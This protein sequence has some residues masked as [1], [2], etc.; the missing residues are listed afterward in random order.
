MSFK[1]RQAWLVAPGRFEI[2]EAEINPGWEDVVVKV[3]AC[4]LCN[5][6]QNHWKGKLGTCPQT[7]GHEVA[8]TIVAIG[9]GIPKGQF[10]EGQPVT[11]FV[12]PM[13][14]FADY[15]LMYRY[16][17]VPLAGNVPLDEA[18]GEPLSCVVTTLRGAAPEAG[19]IGVIVGCG[20]MG[21]WCIQG[22]AGNQLGQIIAVDVNPHRL[23]LARKFGATQT[24]NPS[25]EDAVEKIRQW[26]NWHM[27]DFVIEGTGSPRVLNHCADYLRNGRGRLILM[28]SHEEGDLAFDW[29][30][31]QVKGAQIFVTHPAFST[32]PCDTLRRASLLIN[33]GTFRSTEIISHRFPLER[34]EEAFKTLEHKP[35]DYIKGIVDLSLN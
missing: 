24:V 7:L 1:T 30:K 31:V 21:L 4:G 6:E 34:I 23:S 16:N 29:R 32:D 12:N 5:W 22:L 8:G 35:A 28:S 25:E 19:D 27:A 11:G 3:R 33:K 9:Q 10:Y 26:S 14:G 2:R 18:L 15:A 17:C 20:P 13:A